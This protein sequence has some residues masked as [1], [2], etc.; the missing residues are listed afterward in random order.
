MP[1]LMTASRVFGMDD[2]PGGDS[3]LYDEL[4]T[5]LNSIFIQGCPGMSLLWKRATATGFPRLFGCGSGHDWAVDFSRHAIGGPRGSSRSGRPRIC[6]AAWAVRTRANPSQTVLAA[7]VF[8]RCLC[9]RTLSTESRC[10]GRAFSDSKRGAE[11]RKAGGG[12]VA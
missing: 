2:W 1:G 11:V 7:C 5:N 10:L 6:Y 8:V 4:Q 12:V 3:P 9:L